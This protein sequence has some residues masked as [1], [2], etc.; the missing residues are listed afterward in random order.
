M[1]KSLWITY[2]WA[3]NDEGDFDYLVQE[4]EGASIPAIYDKIA[5]IPGRKLRDTQKELFLLLIKER[6]YHICT[7]IIFKAYVDGYY[8]GSFEVTSSIDHMPVLAWLVKGWHKIRFDQ[9]KGC[10][11]FI[12]LKVWKI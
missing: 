3:D 8:A 10:G 11:W 9:L 6:S 7:N 4:L 12:S 2:A 1:N 5:Q